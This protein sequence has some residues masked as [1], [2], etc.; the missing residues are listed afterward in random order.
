AASAAHTLER[1]TAGRRATRRRGQNVSASMR[2][3]LMTSIGEQPVE[4]AGAEKATVARKL[5]VSETAGDFPPA[6]FTSTM[7]ARDPRVGGDTAIPTMNPMGASLRFGS[8]KVAQGVR[9]DDGPGS[10]LAV[11]CSGVTL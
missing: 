7:P 5:R 6:T 11:T 3:R 10:G 8:W 2:T 1:K 4:S 9:P